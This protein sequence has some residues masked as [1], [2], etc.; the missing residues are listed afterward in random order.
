MQVGITF[1]IS[2]FMSHDQLYIHYQR[3]VLPWDTYVEH[4]CAQGCL[5][6]QKMPEPDNNVNDSE[7]SVQSSKDKEKDKDKKKEKD[8]EKEKE[9]E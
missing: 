5:P 1:P 7:E 3:G 4:A 6:H 9:V 2:P 8:K